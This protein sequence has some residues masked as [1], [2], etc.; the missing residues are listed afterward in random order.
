MSKFNAQNET[1]KIVSW[2]KD[3]YNKN[4]FKGAVLGISGGKDSAVVVALLCEALG[5]ENVIGLTLPCHSKD[6]DKNLAQ[7]VADKYGFEL[8]N[9]DL[10]QT[11]DTLTL[12]FNKDKQYSSEQTK[13]SDINLKPR[14]RMA[15]TYYEAALLS[16]VRGGI[17]LVAGT[18]NAAEYYVGY[19]TK[20]GDAGYDFNPIHD[21]TVQEVIAIGE[22]LDVP[23]EVLYRVPDDGLSSMS[24]EEKMGI[25]YSDV[26]KV[27]RN[28]DIE[29]V[30]KEALE[31]IEYLHR[32]N[33]HKILP[34]P[35]PEYNGE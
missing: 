17:W 12:E 33:L 20:W 1:K 16:A 19:S 21:Y 32:I 27:I 30:S 29:T 31:R 18:G 3:Y 5:P 35:H 24:D 9:I 15:A 25:K 14:L 4:N 28:E 10:T 23:K 6:K 8:K 2:I 13:N 11:F 22:V 34:I 7:V 26:H